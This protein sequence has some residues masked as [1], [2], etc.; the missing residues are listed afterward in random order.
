MWWW[1]LGLLVAWTPVLV[2]WLLCWLD[3]FSA[4][5]LRKLLRS[6]IGVRG[7]GEVILPFPH[8]SIAHFSLSLFFG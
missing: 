2:S 7:I 5:S 4:S 8:S 6:V 1:R 3:C